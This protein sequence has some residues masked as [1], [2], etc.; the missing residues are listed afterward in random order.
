M[1]LLVHVK[2]DGNDTDRMSAHDDLL[3]GYGEAL[4]TLAEEFMPTQVVTLMKVSA[5]TNTFET[6]LVV[7][8]KRFFEYRA[9]RQQFQLEIADEDA[10]LTTAM[11]SATH[12]KIDNDY[13]VISQADTVPPK[14]VDVTWKL[15]CE[16]FTK[17]GQ[18]APIY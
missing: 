16:R 14:G 9:Y 3:E 6:V 1:A 2:N 7:T 10:A 12:V 18:F 11:A 13:Y 8:E 5:T 15:F 4:D 17:R